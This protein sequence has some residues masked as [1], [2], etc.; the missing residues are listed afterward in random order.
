MSFLTVHAV[1][2]TSSTVNAEVDQAEDANHVTLTFWS[3]YKSTTP[4]FLF[5]SFSK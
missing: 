3:K 1:T 4:S 5:V 2:G